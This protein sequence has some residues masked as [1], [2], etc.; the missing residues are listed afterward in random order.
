MVAESEQALWLSIL[1]NYLLTKK[2][3]PALGCGKFGM[4]GNALT[5]SE[6]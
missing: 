6:G 5:F 2:F 1:Q 4:L 3:L